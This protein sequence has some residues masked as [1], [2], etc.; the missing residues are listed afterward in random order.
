LLICSTYWD[1]HTVSIIGPAI[2]RNTKALIGSEVVLF[3]ALAVFNF[4][5]V[6]SNPSEALFAHTYVILGV[7]NF[8]WIAFRNS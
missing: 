2:S 1:F 7:Q 3:K 6:I 5:T 8:I 4:N